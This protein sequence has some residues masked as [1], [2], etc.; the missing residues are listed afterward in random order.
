VIADRS[1]AV[2]MIH[3]AATA[4]EK[5]LGSVVVTG[6]N[7]RISGHLYGIDHMVMMVQRVTYLGSIPL[8]D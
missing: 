6:K 7:M 1:L 8:E 3:A 5:V 2:I 4:V